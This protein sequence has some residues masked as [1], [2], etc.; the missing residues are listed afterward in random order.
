MA[1]EPSNNLG[2]ANLVLS[3]GIDIPLKE[4]QR[5]GAS[6]ALVL[7]CGGTRGDFEVG[8]VRCLYNSG[9]VPKI[10]CG[11]GIGSINAL[12]LAE[13][14][15]GTL[16]SGA[17]DGYVRGLAGL[18]KFWLGLK[19]DRDVWGIE[20]AASTLFT[21]LNRIQGEYEGV[22]NDWNLVEGDV[23]SSNEAG[24]LLSFFIGP[25]SGFVSAAMM[26]GDISKTFNAGELLFNTL[27]AIVSDASNIL[28]ML[29]LNPLELNIRQGNFFLPAL[30]QTS[31]IKLRLAMVAI[32]DG[33]LRYVN[34]TNTMI[35]RDGVTVTPATISSNAPTPSQI[36]ALDQQLAKLKAELKAAES[37][38][39]PPPAPGP[40][41]KP[42]ASPIVT[43]IQASI[44]MVESK[45][46]P[47]F[48]GTLDLIHS[49]LASAS[50]ALFYV[51]RQ[52]QDARTY[53][54]GSSRT[55]LPIASAIKAGASEVYGIVGTQVSLPA[56]TLTQIQSVAS[57]VPL[58]GMTLR[59][60]DDISPAEVARRDVMPDNP[61][62]VPNI[63]IQ[64]SP[65][66]FDDVHDILTV[67]PGLVRIR[68]AYGF[69]RAYDTLW[70][71]KLVGPE[72]YLAQAEINTA[73]GRTAQIINLRK[74]KWNNEFTANKM[75]IRFPSPFLMPPQAYV[76]GP[77]D[78]SPSNMTKSQ[79]ALATITTLKGELLGAIVARQVYYKNLSPSTSGAASM[80]TDFM[81][82]VNTWE[83]HNWNP[84]VQ[85]P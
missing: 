82:W 13:G 28:G 39:P 37:N 60:G 45:L 74:K 69:M 31:N 73:Q 36:A 20:S 56:K 11:S 81:D 44:S 29:N 53:I 35:E 54:S 52:M 72:K 64:P 80:P 75:F 12:K 24:S 40:V 3:Q 21:S 43:S 67:E 42:I 4:G 46:N 17:P 14:E 6:A 32:E 26:A 27:K 55:F 18:E 41:D 15:S 84:T 5:P 79:E 7:S 83:Q 8:A 59:V 58:L 19:T 63:I 2:Q 77:L 61:Y 22:L 49:A 23:N 65:Q 30:V 68:M 16:P 48:S 1:N 78:N 33:A 62:P 71:Y 51:P 70:A 9:L 66:V 85:F 25:F 50:T 38:P 57:V 47:P 10:I 34:E 76:E